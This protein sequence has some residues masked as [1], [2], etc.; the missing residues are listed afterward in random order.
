MAQRLQSRLT[1]GLTLSRNRALNRLVTGFVLLGAV[2]AAKPLRGSDGVTPN[3]PFGP[4][5]LEIE[6]PA[7]PV[8]QSNRTQSPGRF[9][10]DTI[11]LQTEPKTAPKKTD[12]K[13]KQPK[14]DVAPPD[15]GEVTDAPYTVRSIR[16]LTVDVTEQK[17]KNG[18]YFFPKEY[19]TT[20][21]SREE[22]EF[23]TRP[24]CGWREYRLSGPIAPFCF[25]PTYFDDDSLTRF[26]YSRDLWT[27]SLLSATQFYVTVPL[28]PYKMSKKRPCRTVFPC[29]VPP[30]ISLHKKIVYYGRRI[31]AKSVAAEAAAISTVF[32]LFP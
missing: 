12:P 25:L 5:V 9:S 19:E 1:P 16:E 22:V 23:L 18:R 24:D 14:K 28:L 13:K 32:L 8:P 15:P 6:G 4:A 20:P 31:D 27:Q 17:Y 2:A 30:P 26:G 29:Y 3:P 7:S 10:S 11:I 21:H